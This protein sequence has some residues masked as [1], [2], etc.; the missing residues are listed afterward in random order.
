[1]LQVSRISL[2]AVL[3]VS[4]AASY[5]GLANGAGPTSRPI[6]FIIFVADDMAWDDSGPY[7][8]PSVRTPNL[9]RLA[10]Q[11]MRFDRAYLT[12]S[13]CS[14]SRCSMLTGRYPHNTGAGELHLPLPSEQQML[15]TPLRDAGYWTAVVGKWHL[16]EA[17]AEQVDYRKASNPV[18]MGATWVEAIKERPK[19]QPFFI[20][21]AHTDPHR[22]YSPGAVDPPHSPASVQLPPFFPDTPLVR[23]DLALYYDEVCRFDQHIG[24]VLEELEKQSL[25][26][27]TMILVI[28]DNGRPFPHCK[29]MVTVPG[30]R[31]PFIV[32]LPG[33]IPAGQVN[34]QLVSSLDIAPTV[35]DLAGVQ[36]SASMQGASLRKTLTDPNMSI[37]QYAFAE[38]NWHD[39]RAFERAVYDQQ[40]CYLRNWLPGTPATPPADAV[41]SV[42]FREMKRLYDEG[43]LTPEQRACMIAPRAEEYLFDT[44]KDPNCLN[45]L[46]EDPSMKAHLDRLRETLAQWQTQTNDSFSGEDNLTPDG[47]D[48]ET[49]KRIITAAHPN[50]VKS[51]KEKRQKKP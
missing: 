45:N 50:L 25:S 6:N 44:I 48:R 36:R 19:D 35:L 34:D 18:Q 1:M 29:T 17:V 8:N 28:S 7:G 40:F 15:T 9:D 23:E 20:W 51:K 39:Y 13:S 4:Y 49:G 22:G 16:G 33:L 46:A 11:G 41:N 12:C 10:A 2:L 21:A 30:V 3:F 43:S 24:M 32:K 31:T 47:F 42:T 26:D 14:P 27:S 5:L 38:H 37:R